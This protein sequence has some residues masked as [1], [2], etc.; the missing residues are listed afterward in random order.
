[1]QIS[2][3]VLKMATFSVFGFTLAALCYNGLVNLYA[4]GHILVL[5]NKC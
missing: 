5:W 3:F 2:V 1:M 4:I